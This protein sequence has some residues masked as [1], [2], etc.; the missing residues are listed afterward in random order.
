MKYKKF[1]WFIKL[2]VFKNV[3]GITLW[4]FGIYYKDEYVKT[5]TWERHEAIHWG[6]QKEMLGV[7]FYL[8]YFTEYIIRIILCNSQPYRSI[9]F[10]REAYS[11][12]HDKEYKHSFY[13]W[14]KYVLT[15]VK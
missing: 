13:G 8:W 3:T 6:Q 4:P 10:E 1:N 15:N 7:F 9:G 11:N 2:V 5:E 12:E 14:F